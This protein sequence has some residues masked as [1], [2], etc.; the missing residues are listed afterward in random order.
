MSGPASPGKSRCERG[1]VSWVT[2]LLI[3]VV[4]GGGYL[5]WVWIPLY[6]EL[7]T[8]K[9]VVRDY[10]NQAI[11]DRDDEMLRRNMVLKIRSL[12]QVDT[13]DD[14]GHPVRIPAI[15]L[16]ERQVSWERNASAEQPTLRVAFGYERWVVYPILDRTDVKVFEVDLTG[17]LTRADWGPSR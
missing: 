15:L 4:A 10:M 12:E 3:A 2:L 14:R 11:K 13:V 8:V 17:D 7:Y 9:Q 5:G 6:F 16:D 1:Q